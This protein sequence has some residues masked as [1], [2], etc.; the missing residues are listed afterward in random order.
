MHCPNG[1]ENGAFYADLG[2]AAPDLFI[3]PLGRRRKQSRIGAAVSIAV[4]R[5]PKVTSDESLVPLG[6][7]RGRE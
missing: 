5:W 7:A 4:S 6:T 3:G 2:P 1:I